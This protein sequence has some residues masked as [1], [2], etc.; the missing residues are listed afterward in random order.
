MKFPVEEGDILLLE[1]SYP[2]F[3]LNRQRSSEVLT[4]A[5]IYTT[6]QNS[7]GL[8]KVGHCFFFSQLTQTYE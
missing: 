2:A 8:S 4:L 7:E 1:S 3:F 6:V 5:S